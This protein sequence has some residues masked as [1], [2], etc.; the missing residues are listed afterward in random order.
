MWI[1]TTANDLIH[2]NIFEDLLKEFFSIM[3]RQKKSKILQDN[4]GSCIDV[5]Q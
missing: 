2:F 5:Q 4:D 1:V 3:C